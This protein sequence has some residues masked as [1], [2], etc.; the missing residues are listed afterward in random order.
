MLLTH[1]SSL[2]ELDELLAAS[3]ETP[4]VFF[5]HSTRCPVSSG[6]QSEFMAWARSLPEDAKVRLAHLDLIRHRDVSSAIAERLG[7]MHESPQ[8]IL[9]RGGQA[10]WN[11]SHYSITQ[12]SLS[13]ALAKAG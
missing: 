12:A 3:Q 8:A 2:A 7:I 13:A 10:T 5:K 4:V 6:A 9:V 1:L 11:A